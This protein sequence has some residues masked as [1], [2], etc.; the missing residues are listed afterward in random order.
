MSCL[1]VGLSAAVSASFS[2]SVCFTSSLSLT[3]TFSGLRGG[4]GEQGPYPPHL[5]PF[6][7]QKSPQ[8]A[9]LPL[10]PSAFRDQT[11]AF[12][13]WDP[14]PQPLLGSP[15][16]LQDKSRGSLLFRMR[17]SRD[18]HLSSSGRPA[19]RSCPRRHHTGGSEMRASES[20]AGHGGKQALA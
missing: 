20:K 6:V 10:T 3:L 18:G 1:Q 15:N 16:I 9:L 4:W 19:R 7:L 12:L 8:S 11:L 5:V 17:R 2:K 13:P 14:L